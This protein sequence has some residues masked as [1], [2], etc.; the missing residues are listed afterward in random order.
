MADGAD[1]QLE[2]RDCALPGRPA[3]PAV[4][5][6]SRPSLSPP[7]ANSAERHDPP[8]AECPPA[9][10]AAAIGGRTAAFRSAAVACGLITLVVAGAATLPRFA[11][12][13]TGG[14]A[15]RP[16]VAAAPGAGRTTPGR[17]AP[18][19]TT[20]DAVL[21]G[22]A[23]A[24][25]HHDRA[26][27][28]AGVDGGSRARQAAEFDRVTA[29]P[30]VRWRY[31]V[32]GP[33][34]ATHPAGVGSGPS[35]A[36]V[37]LTYRLAGDTRDVVRPRTVTFLP[38]GGTWR[39]T[40]EEPATA[41]DRDLWDLGALGVARGSRAVAV[42]LPGAPSAAPEL[43]R[44]ADAAAGAVDAVW[45][46]SWPR[47][48][49]VVLPADPDQM[50]AVLGR[51][52]TRGLDR[53]AAVTVGRLDRGRTGPEA[54]AGAADR[55]VL[56]PVVWARLTD[57][58]RQTVLAHELTH[59]ATRATTSATPPTWLDEGL[60]GYVGYRGTGLRDAEIA[61]DALPAVQAGRLPAGLPG[62]DAFDPA[63]GDPDPAYAQAWVACDLVVRR[64]GIPGLVAVYRAAA[65]AGGGEGR[66]DAALLQVLGES[67]DTFV[68][69]WRQRLQMLAGAGR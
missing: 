53:L 33:A 65:S 27:W 55:V 43:A 69:Q 3:V 19:K 64:A 10:P 51:A 2:E 61:A 54:V 37:E 42:S 9:R 58:G 4:P 38:E 49:I 32:V 47:P 29:L 52:D 50:A 62:A 48:V 1:A 16:G 24:L 35:A 12:P 45:G 60:A 44:R 67:A 63:R 28:L 68:V 25:L 23:T 21:A 56:N 6:A 13:A 39:L 31:R 34:P 30:V 18:A 15:A 7:G 5:L 36:A 11:G 66:A 17:A 8:A 20:L 46:A 57:A 22:R 26:G 14:A 59:V 40:S 41:A